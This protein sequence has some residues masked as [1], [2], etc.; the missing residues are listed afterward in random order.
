MILSDLFTTD[1]DLSQGFWCCNC[2]LCTFAVDIT[3]ETDGSGELF[4]EL[5]RWLLLVETFHFSISWPPLERVITAGLLLAFILK[6]LWLQGEASIIPAFKRFSW[7]AMG[8][9]F[10]KKM[11][12]K[13][14]YSIDPSPLPFKKSRAWSSWRKRRERNRNKIKRKGEKEGD[15]EGKGERKREKEGE[16]AHSYQFLPGHWQTGTGM[17][18]WEESGLPVISPRKLSTH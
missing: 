5:L 10:Q 14:I 9:T 1:D 13:L 2:C 12:R 7:K 4:R 17:D 15:L 3:V 18:C 11:K 6:V 16:R 8:Q